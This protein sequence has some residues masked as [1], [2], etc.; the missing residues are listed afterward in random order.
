MSYVLFWLLKAGYYK[1]NS[2]E[3]CISQHRTRLPCVKI[4][5][6]KAP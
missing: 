1:K 6:A 2:G 4:W 3:K 5:Q